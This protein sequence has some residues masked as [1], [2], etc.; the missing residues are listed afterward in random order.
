MRWNDRGSPIEPS[1]R[2]PGDDDG[3]ELAGVQ[4]DVR[5]GPG[6]GCCSAWVVYLRSHGATVNI[7]DDADRAAFRA[8]RGVPV[9]V[10][11]CHTATVFGYTIEGHVPVRAIER[12]LSAQPD[13]VGLAL[14]AMPADSPGMGG[15]NTTWDRQAVQLIGP[16][17]QLSAFDY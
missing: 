10:A 5:R 2:E 11:S 6:C 3:T 17:G 1:E 4:I 7:V 8:G 9:E 16:A 15:D 13:A 12:L 14:A